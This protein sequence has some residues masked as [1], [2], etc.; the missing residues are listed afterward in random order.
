MFARHFSSDGDE[1]RKDVFAPVAD[2]MVGVLFI[3][4]LLMFAL[5]LNF[6]PDKVVRLHPLKAALPARPGV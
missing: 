2:L 5:S 1:D 4:I 3:F 6:Q